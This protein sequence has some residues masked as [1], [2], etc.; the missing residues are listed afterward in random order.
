MSYLQSCSN[1]PT[2]CQCHSEFP[3]K[4]CPLTA[5]DKY[6][7]TNRNF[8]VAKSNKYY[9]QVLTD[10][11]RYASG[12]ISN[13]G[14]AFLP[15]GNLNAR[16]LKYLLTSRILSKGFSLFQQNGRVRSSVASLSFL[17]NPFFIYKI[18]PHRKYDV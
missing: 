3:N 9:V 14:L 15:L 5:Q 10:I 2:L 12:G 18:V 6:Q 13:W 16:G 8:Q 11:I 7:Q 17:L 1:Y 4:H